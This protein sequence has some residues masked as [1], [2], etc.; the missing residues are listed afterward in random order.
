MQ[1]KTVSATRGV[2]WFKQGWTLFSK[3]MVNW[4]LMALVAG[5]GIFLLNFLPIIGQIVM[6]LLIPAVLGG[7]LYAAQQA[8]NGAPVKLEYLWVVLQD[9]K[10]RNPF[11]V[12]G[13]ILFA[14]VVTVGIISV[15]FVGDSLLMG[16]KSGLPGFGFGGML[17]MLVVGF[18]FFVLFYYTPALMLFHDL[19][20]FDAL[21]ACASM[22]ST[23]VVPLLVFFLIYVVL[24][25][26][27]SIPFGLGMLVLFPVVIAAIYV[28]C[29][30]LCAE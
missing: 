11:L 26:I 22:A 30:E 10:K 4:V 12:L 15:A 5:V 3:D 21:K 9:A 24:G 2:D 1:V 6:C 16:A 25:F 18:V 8:S 27:A 28:S 23:Q 13:G 29:M 7:F 14:A 20:L 19:S 17:F